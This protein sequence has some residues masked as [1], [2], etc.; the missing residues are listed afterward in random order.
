MYMRVVVVTVSGSWPHTGSSLNFSSDSIP[1]IT[2]K[3][4]VKVSIPQHDVHL[5][6]Q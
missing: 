4:L 2:Q 3:A 6:P 5:A 1:Y